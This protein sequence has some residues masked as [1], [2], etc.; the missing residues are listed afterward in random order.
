[1]AQVISEKQK[2]LNKKLHEENNDFGMRDAA[3]GLA[4]KLPSSIKRMN[5]L[6]LCKSVLDY[7]TGKGSIVKRL[8]KELPET[9]QI[10]GY[11]PAVAAFDKK[12]EKP[13]DILTCMDVLEHIEI[14][15]IDSVLEDIKNLTRNFC[16]LIIDL[17]PAVKSLANGRNAHILLAPSDWW[18]N[19]ISQHFS[20]QSSF[21][22]LHER[23]LPQKII[24]GATNK[25]E[26]VPYMYS[27][28]AKMKLFD[29]TMVGGPLGKVK[30]SKPN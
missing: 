4:K 18:V 2:Q 25:R 23:G 21:P 30:Q 15:D 19:K 29:F 17:Q 13:S 22:I 27:F 24:V 14:N 20:C 3:G 10:I 12:P 8:K 26:I 1:M 7:G 28:L 11:D 6:G 9:I 5:E 16:Y